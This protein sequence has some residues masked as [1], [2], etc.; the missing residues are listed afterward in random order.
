MNLTRRR[1]GLSLAF[2][3]LL[4]TTGCG[5]DPDA[6]GDKGIGPPGVPSP[7]GA[8]SSEDAEKKRLEI[9]AKNNADPNYAKAASGR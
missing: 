9:E 2:L 3:G 8:Q 7:E 4:G 1:F 5:T 6:T